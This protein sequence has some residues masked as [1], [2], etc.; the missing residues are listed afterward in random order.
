MLLRYFRKI[1]AYSG[2]RLFA[3][4]LVCGIVVV[5][6]SGDSRR[7]HFLFLLLFFFSGL[8]CWTFF[9]DR[10]AF[11]GSQFR[12]L[13]AVLFVILWSSEFVSHMFLI[14]A[15]I[16]ESN[17]QFT[18]NFRRRRNPVWIL[19]SAMFSALTII[20]ISHDAWFIGVASFIM[21]IIVGK[22]QVI[23]VLQWI[24]GFVLAIIVPLMLSRKFFPDFQYTMPEMQ[25]VPLEWWIVPALVFLLSLN[26]FITFYRKADNLNKS[27]SL[28]AVIW[29]VLGVLFAF[30]VGGEGGF[31]LV[32]LGLSYQAS[33]AMYYF[34]R[35]T[36]VE[37]GFLLLMI[38]SVAYS[39]NYIEFL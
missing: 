6:T 11:K 21:L 37:I 2:L 13:V 1:D 3:L 12:F 28:L 30:L 4:V 31:V 16:L 25:E 24:F 33:Y 29:T 14:A 35:R 20:F 17:W 9:K 7:D 27:R 38:Y 32:L 34:K 26:Q 22:P 19:H 36:W 10:W 5:L 15:L 8:L 39:V 18:E 23:H